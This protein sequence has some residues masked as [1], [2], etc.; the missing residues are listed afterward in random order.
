M[1]FNRSD[2]RMDSMKAMD[3]S[4]KFRATLLVSKDS[5]YLVCFFF[6]SVRFGVIFSGR[7]ACEH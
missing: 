7:N 2:C 3:N 6:T 4:R 1:I 5:S